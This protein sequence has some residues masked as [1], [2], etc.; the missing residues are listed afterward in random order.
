MTFQLGESNVELTANEAHRKIQDDLFYDVF[1]TEY[2]RY[3]DYLKL[4]INEWHL[5]YKQCREK[6]MKF[7]TIEHANVD[8]ANKVEDFK[9]FLDTAYGFQHATPLLTIRNDL[10]EVLVNNTEQIIQNH[11]LELETAENEFR[12]LNTEYNEKNTENN[13]LKQEVNQKKEAANAKAAEYQK[14]QDECER[15]EQLYKKNKKIIIEKR[16][17][18]ANSKHDAN[19]A[20]EEL[21]FTNEEKAKYEDTDGEPCCSHLSVLLGGFHQKYISTFRLTLYT[22]IILLG[23]VS[24][25]GIFTCVHPFENDTDSKYFL[26]FWFL[27]YI[28]AFLSCALFVFTK[29]LLDNKNFDTIFFLSDRRVLISILNLVLIGLIILY[30]FFNTEM[31]ACLVIRAFQGLIVGFLSI[32]YPV[33]LFQLGKT[34]QPLYLFSFFL[35]FLAFGVIFCVPLQQKWPLYIVIFPG[36]QTIL[37]WF[38]SKSS[39]N[40]VNL[41]FEFRVDFKFHLEFLVIGLHILQPFLGPFT[42]WTLISRVYSNPLDNVR[43]IIPFVV[44]SFVFCVFLII[45]RMRSDNTFGLASIIVS[46]PCLVFAFIGTLLIILHKDYYGLMI[47]SFSNGIGLLQ[48]PW[49]PYYETRTRM[50]PKTFGFYWGLYWLSTSISSAILTNLSLYHLSFVWLSIILVI[51]IFFSLYLTFFKLDTCHTIL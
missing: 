47:M 2:E 13:N 9:A 28:G 26:L 43:F 22:L 44:G 3:L 1:E 8:L 31:A 12:V 42:L 45:L 36:L 29:R 6:E 46:I 24:I 50:R 51:I 41:K 5:L 17:E 7:G 39:F 40:F 18:L 11:K 21:D 23:A 20:Q 37:I 15:K 27:P 49:L 33:S 10:D 16:I 35:V 38:I 34:K 4:D 19:L 25:S 14:L 30:Y 32:V 48:L